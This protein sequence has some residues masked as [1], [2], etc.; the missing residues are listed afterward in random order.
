MVRLRQ[1]IDVQR[2]TPRGGPRATPERV[3]LLSNYAWGAARHTLESACTEAGMRFEHVG[4][5]ARSSLTPEVEIAASDITVAVGRAALEGMASGRCVYVLDRFAGDGWVTPDSYPAFESDGFGGL[6][7]NGTIDAARLRRDLAR[8]DRQMGVL[9]RQLIFKRHHAM[10]HARELVELLRRLA[11]GPPRPRAP[12]DEMARLVRVQWQAESR[13]A[14][15]AAEN[16]A[17]RDEIERERVEARAAVAAA[18]TALAAF[19]RTRRYRLARL[20]GRPLDVLRRRG[21]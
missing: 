8:Y 7:S 20:L 21:G 19:Q 11:P 9:N 12:L 10:E 3:L 15:L 6:A 18:H 14:T 16:A 17:L 1:P 5:P 4:T 2:F 13:A